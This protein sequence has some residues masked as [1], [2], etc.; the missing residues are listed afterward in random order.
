MQRLGALLFCLVAGAAMA[1]AQTSVGSTTSSSTTTTITK[2]PQ[3]IALAQ[4]ALAAMGGLQAIA[5]ITDSRASGT[6]TIAA[7][8]ASP[9][10]I[11]LET[12]GTLKV[13]STLARPS[14]SVVRILNGGVA[15]VI[16]A[17][18]SV[19]KLDANNTM[20]QRVDHI[21]LLS[22]ISEYQN[23]NIEITLGAAPNTFAATLIPTTALADYYRGITKT[24]FTVD[25]NSGLITSMQFTAHGEGSMKDTYQ[26]Q[27]VYANYQAV[28]GVMVP[29]HQT[30]YE[31]GTM[32]T[33]LV[34]SSIAFNVGVPDSDFTLPA[35]V[36]NAN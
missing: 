5:T 17:D 18:D 36:V 16:H 7:D 22:L 24:I 15:A 28:N 2:D 13:R 11:T 31:N 30:T 21:P 3:A 32:T 4:K 6:F 26:V 12:Q 27:I 23:A 9:Y 33:D 14:G 19:R 20:A 10:P 1:A 25:P 34:L 8:A 35:E 29:F